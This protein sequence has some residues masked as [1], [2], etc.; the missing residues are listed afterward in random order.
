MGDQ[1]LDERDAGLALQIDADALLVQIVAQVRGAHALAVDIR[2]GRQGAPGR[3][4]GFRVLDLHHLGA[5]ASHQLGRVGERLHLLDGQD[6]DALEG[7]VHR[8]V[9]LGEDA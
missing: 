3:F 7:S 4:A 5:Q 8:C 2:Y 9:L 6:A 1:P